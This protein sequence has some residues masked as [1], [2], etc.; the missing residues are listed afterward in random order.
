MSQGMR[1]AL[2]ASPGRSMPHLR[3]RIF[4]GLEVRARYEK[5]W[6]LLATVLEV[7]LDDNGQ[8]RNRKCLIHGVKYT[9]DVKGSE[10][11]DCFHKTMRLV[12]IIHEQ[13]S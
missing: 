9:P 3:K 1:R 7:D 6:K 8:F 10:Y 4:T 12:G 13:V 5:A 11:I 2:S